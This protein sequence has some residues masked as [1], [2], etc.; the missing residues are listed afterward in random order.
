MDQWTTASF[1]LVSDGAGWRCGAA[2]L[3]L[4]DWLLP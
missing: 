3:D 2:P 1:C 4:A